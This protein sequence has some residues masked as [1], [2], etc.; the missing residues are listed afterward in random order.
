MRT[1][2]LLL[3]PIF[4]LLLCQVT[5]GKSI[6]EKKSNDT[7]T[8]QLNPFTQIE[9][10]G[11]F[12]IELIQGSQEF[13]DI[14][15]PKDD[16]GYLRTDIN[17]GKLRIWIDKSI[18]LNKFTLKIHFKNLKEIV[19]NGGVSL[20]S[21]KE[22]KAKDLSIKVFG[23]AEINLPI[24]CSVFSV[25]LSGG[26]SAEFTGKTINAKFALNGAGKIEALKLI[27]DSVKVDI[28]G[29]GY[30]EVYA[31]KAVDASI[32]GVGSIQYAGNPSKVKSDIAGMGSIEEKK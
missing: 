31:S 20:K 6:F 7:S 2:L 26:T 27:A 16:I 8:I 10:N 22:I 25:N 23:G 21:N 14:E 13:I 12:E 1:K 15:A 24:N 30:A 9:T 17:E 5:N 11:G 32:T 19:I 18:Q 4:V 28:A 29:A 3:T